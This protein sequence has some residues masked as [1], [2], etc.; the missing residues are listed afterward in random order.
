MLELREL[1][2]RDRWHPGAAQAL[3][4][5]RYLDVGA[6]SLPESHSRVF[7]EFAGLPRPA[8]NVLLGD[9]PDAPTT[10][11]WLEQW[12]TALEYEGAH[13]FTDPEQVR[14]DIGRYAWMR[15]RDVNYVQITRH[16]HARPRALVLTAY[17]ALVDRGYTGPRPEFGARW[18]QLFARPPVERSAGNL[19][20][21]DEVAS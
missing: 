18:H 21:G 7:L 13:H 15:R 3:W 6:A 11:L 5:S 12:R 16:L 10:D 4:V 17:S 14:R 8:V 20:R 2:H 19:I 1:A 9:E